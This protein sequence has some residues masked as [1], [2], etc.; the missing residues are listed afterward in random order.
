MA[1]KYRLPTSLFGRQQDQ[2]PDN[3]LEWPNVWLL[4]FGTIYT[5]VY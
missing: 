1:C 3:D 2:K 5:K 4:H